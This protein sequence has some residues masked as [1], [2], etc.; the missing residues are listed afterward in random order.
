MKQLLFIIMASFIVSCAQDETHDNR[1]VTFFPIAGNI[2]ADLRQLD[3]LPVGIN[4]YT[5]L[6]GMT[7][8]SLAS[9][10]ELRASAAEMT[11]PDISSPEIRNFYKETVF[12]DKTS[13]HLT[14]SYVTEAGKP[15]VKKVEVMIRQETD[16]LRSIFVE[17]YFTRNDSAINRRMVW[18]PGRSMQMTDICSSGGKETVKTVKYAWGVGD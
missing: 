10:E 6:D 11:N 18:S 1:D 15:T 2:N 17:K 13:D 16:K 3:S 14:I 8:T 4:K 9:R 12:Y 5:T 7:D